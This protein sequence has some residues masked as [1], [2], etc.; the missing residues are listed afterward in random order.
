VIE[1]EVDPDPKR[2]GLVGQIASIVP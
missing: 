2:A 1:V